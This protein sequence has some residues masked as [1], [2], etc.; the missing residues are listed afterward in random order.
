MP[1]VMSYLIQLYNSASRESRIMIRSSLTL[2]V[3]TIIALTNAGLAIHYRSI[4]MLVLSG[5]YLILLLA[6]GYDV[7]DISNRRKHH[8]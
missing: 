1:K 2:P 7:D 5:Y 6:R 4:W 3:S 8:Y